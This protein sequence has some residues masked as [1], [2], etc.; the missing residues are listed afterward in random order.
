MIGTKKDINSPLA[1]W[2]QNFNAFE[3]MLLWMYCCTSGQFV[4]E[5]KNGDGSSW[6]TTHNFQF[7]RAIQSPFII[8]KQDFNTD[9]LAGRFFVTQ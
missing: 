8:Y 5:E 2:K 3:Q 4:A 7:S 6:Q 1:S 9:G